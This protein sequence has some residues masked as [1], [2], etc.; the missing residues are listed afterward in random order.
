MAILKEIE[1]AIVVNGQELKEYDDEDAGNDDQ[2]SVSKYVEA[3]SGA[4]F[5]IVTSAPIWFEFSSDAVMMKIYLDGAYVENVLFQKE[6]AGR[7]KAWQRTV[8]G[9]RRFNGNRWVV[10]PFKF[11]EITAGMPYWLLNFV[12]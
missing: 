9:A 3:T 7:T 2:N 4:E 10:K 11:V 12:D 6:E 1:V 8:D 5:Q